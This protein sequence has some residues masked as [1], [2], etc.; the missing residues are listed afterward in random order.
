LK[1][2][3]QG[4]K[5]FKDR[6]Q[7]VTYCA[8]LSEQS[9]LRFYTFKNSDGNCPVTF[10]TARLKVDF[11]LNLH[12]KANA[13]VNFSSVFSFHAQHFSLYVSVLVREFYV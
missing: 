1:N 3:A 2:S 8:L 4:K 11:E 6:L 13:G 9:E 7:S 12:S 5:F 10:F